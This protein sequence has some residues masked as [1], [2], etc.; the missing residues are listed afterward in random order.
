MTPSHPLHLTVHCCMSG[1]SRTSL[2]SVAFALVALLFVAVEGRAGEIVAV[3]TAAADVIEITVRAPAA[4][5]PPS[6]RAADWSIA[7]AAPLAVGRWSTVWDEG[8]VVTDASIV[9]RHRIYLLLN[10]PLQSGAAYT[11]GT[12][13]GT[14][15][16]RFDEDTT[17]CA[18][19][20]AN[21]VGYRGGSAATYAMLGVYLGDLGTRTLSSPPAYR[22]VSEADGSVLMRGRALFRAADTGADAMSGTMAYVLDL[23]GLPAGGPYHIVVEG[24]GRSQGF[25]VGDRYVRELYTVHARGLYHQRCGIALEEPYTHHTRPICH[26]RA[27]VTD[28]EPEN[29]VTAHGPPMEIHGGYH[30]AGDFDRRPAHTLIPAWMLMTYEAFPD[31]FADGDLNIP[32]SGNGIPDWLD[33]AIWGTAVWAYLQTPDGG[34][35]AGTEADRHPT[36]GEVNAATDDLVYRTFRVD[37]HTTATACGLFAHVARLLRPFDSARAAA[38]LGRAERAWAFME[39]GPLPNLHTAQHMYAALELYL[40]TGDGRYHAA[41]RTDAAALLANPPYPE[42]YNPFY[43]NA[44][45]IRDGQIFAPYF[46]SYLITS[47]PTD[48]TI[49]RG[50]AGMIAT[51]AN[52]VLRALQAN[53]YPSGTTYAP[54]WG[55][56]TAQGRYAEP[57]LLAYRINGERRLLDAAGIMADYCAGLNPLGVCWVTGL[58]AVSP[59]GPTQLDSYFTRERGLGPVPGIVPYGPFRTPG[60]ISYQK[61]IWSKAYPAWSALPLHLRW[62]EGWSL[63]PVNEFTTLETMVPNACLFAALLEPVKPSGVAD[64]SATAAHDAE[65]MRLE[66]APSVVRTSATIT[67]RAVGTSRATVDV[68]GA[69]GRRVA[70]PADAIGAGG[71]LR[72]EWDAADDA[73]CPLPNGWYLLRAEAAGRVSVLKVLVVR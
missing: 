56:A 58:G 28:A 67:L 18:S 7:G 11:L 42:Q 41:F 53:A 21:Q 64:P 13:Y 25:G 1:H 63:I 47:L 60:D 61:I 32:E 52:A 31:R 45:T 68:L 50:L 55:S 15:A 17:L 33:E 69:D 16:F 19:I 70:R 10:A 37:G 29:F 27:E 20:H 24:W 35:R 57:L 3:G 40:A 6:G 38:V 23:T 71:T 26:V 62:S 46:F 59:H 72:F 34:V 39:R 73:G 66:C 14:R 8:P 48:S 65:A 9:M 36:Y 43:W 4:E 51:Q 30:D 22:V 5:A 54:A 49:R 2:S 12:P 44:E